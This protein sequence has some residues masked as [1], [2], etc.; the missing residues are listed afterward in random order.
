MREMCETCVFRPGNRMRLKGGRLR[1]MV[2]DS[3]KGDG[4]GITCHKTLHWASDAGEA[5]CRGFFDRY[6][7]SP[8]QIA[9]RLGF[10]KEVDEPHE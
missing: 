7:T 3:R 5:I 4:G 2:E 6:A 1:Q 10:I 9:D 8:M